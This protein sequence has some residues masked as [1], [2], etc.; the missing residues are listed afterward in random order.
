VDAPIIAVIGTDCALGKRTTCRLVKQACTAAG[1]NAQMIYT[2]Q[3][4]W[5][6][7]GKYGFIFDTTLNDFISGEIEHAIVSCRQ[8][9]NPDLIL[10]EG[11][12]SLRNPSGPCGS[13]LLVS[14]KAKYTILVHAPKRI[15]YDHL[16][17]WG[18][19]PSVKSEIDL[20]GMYNSEVIALALNTEL[21]TDEEAFAFQRQ[22][23]NELNVPVLLPI[24]EG[25]SK[26][27][28]VIR[29]LI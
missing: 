16:P 26:I 2:G 24:Q 13:E 4:G 14:G 15:Y 20:I 25:V 29:S 11:Q 5:M 28:P 10:I 27:I 23:E 7:G 17:E 18:R 22:F 21:C 3:T 8:E 12:S 6:Q 19:I 9:T 1:L